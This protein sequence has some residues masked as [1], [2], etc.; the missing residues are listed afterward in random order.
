VISPL[1]A[2]IYL[3][4]M[5]KFLEK[6]LGAN[7]IRSKKEENARRTKGGRRIEN[8]ISRL[9]SW[10]K[11]GKK[12]SNYT[13]R[14]EGTPLTAEMRKDFIKELKALEKERKKIPNL[15]VRQKIGFIRYADDYL[16]IL[17]KHSK[18]EAE[19]VKTKIGEYLK[20]HLKLEQSEEKTLISHPTDSITFL[21]YELTSKGKR[22]KGLCL[23]IPKKA[24][25]GLLTE[26][27]RLCRLH[28]IPEADLFMKVNAILRGWMNYYRYASAPQRTF[29]A[30]CHKVFWQVSHYLAGRHK[31]TL[32]TIVRTYGTTAIIN[33]RSRATLIKLV[34]GK[35]ITLWIH[36]P[37]TESIYVIKSGKQEDDAKP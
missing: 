10:L 14:E 35:P 7:A 24:I 34:N 37:K 15:E 30:I 28:H 31:T 23:N 19:A 16:V 13:K 9:R 22:R 1:L 5:D 3:T 27:E 8:R 11:T 17:Q 20:T 36:P 2:N 18:A 12:W 25:D 26:T 21:G 29:N 6:T 33:G 4:E 32:P